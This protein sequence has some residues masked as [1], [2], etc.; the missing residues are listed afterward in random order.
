MINSEILSLILIIFRLWQRHLQ[1]W[2]EWNTG[3]LLGVKRIV[4]MEQGLW[5]EF[6]MHSTNKSYG[7]DCCSGDNVVG[8]PNNDD[9]DNTYSTAQK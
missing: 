6:H 1:C 9:N 7:K 8:I 3:E 2:R 4:E 5:L